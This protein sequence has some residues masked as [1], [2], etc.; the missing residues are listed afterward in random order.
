MTNAELN[1]V[2]DKLRYAQLLLHSIDKRTFD[3]CTDKRKNAINA[4]S[5]Y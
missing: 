3:E 5:I 1:L 4:Q 2:L